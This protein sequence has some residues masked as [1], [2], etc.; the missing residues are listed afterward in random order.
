M[1]VRK[2]LQH[3]LTHGHLQFLPAILN[4]F[5]KSRMGFFQS[6]T[7]CYLAKNHLN[8]THKFFVSVIFQI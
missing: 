5:Q 3:L 6:I 8:G 2:N 1:E 7:F 4:I